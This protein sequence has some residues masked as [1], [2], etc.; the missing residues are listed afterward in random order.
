MKN[1]IEFILRV[2]LKLV[3]KIK[4]EVKIWDMD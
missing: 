2:L 1:L 4:T 3:F